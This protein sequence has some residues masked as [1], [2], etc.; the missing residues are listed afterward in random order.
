MKQTVISKSIVFPSIPM[1]LTVLASGL[2]AIHLTLTWRVGSPDFQ[3]SSLLFWLTAVYFIWQRRDQ[4]KLKAS[5]GASL[6]GF[7]VLFLLLLKSTAVTSQGF[8]LIYPFL[9]G[10]SLAL[11]ASGFRGLYQYWKELALLFFLGIPK[12]ILP[13][14]VDP[15]LLTASLAATL[16][17]FAGFAVV[18]QGIHLNFAEVAVSV[19]PGCSG[20]E[21]MLQL[22]SLAVLFFI[23]LPLPWHWSQKLSLP[24]AAIAISF[25][26]NSVRVALLAI[27]VA[28]RQSDA[29]FEYWH[30]GQGSLI[31]SG[32]AALL[33]VLFVWV[34]IQLSVVRSSDPENPMTS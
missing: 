31:F 26:V 33:F 15:S 2:V 27:L 16:L 18:Q 32:V 28:Q 23:V 20:L 5:V 6:L 11:L 25:A 14:L 1:L 29:I 19:F 17:R 7:F 4:F 24:L 12:F 21:L 30:F 3:V 8:L 10:M 22:L 34:L 13:S 9:A